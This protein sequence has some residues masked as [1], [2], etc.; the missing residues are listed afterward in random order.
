M[1]HKRIVNPLLLDI[2]FLET[3]FRFDEAR[4]QAQR[5]ISNVDN[6]ASRLRTNDVLVSDMVSTFFE[7]LRRLLWHIVILLSILTQLETQLDSNS[8]LLR[9]AIASNKQVALDLKRDEECGQKILN[10]LKMAE[11]FI[12]GQMEVSSQQI[13]AQSST[14]DEIEILKQFI[15][16]T[17]LEVRE[18]EEGTQKKI[19]NEAEKIP[20]QDKELAKL[21]EQ[22]PKLYEECQKLRQ[23]VE[24]NT[25]Q[26]I[27]QRNETDAK[28]TKM[29]AKQEEMEHIRREWEATS[30]WQKI[31]ACIKWVL[32]GGSW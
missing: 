19:A 30:T 12:Q 21:R 24:L 20:Q 31:W 16:R 22:V 7:F 6:N 9:V 4:A 25:K 10:E 14:S 28:V 23:T 11:N 13:E 17:R 15:G 26:A 3:R 32:S 5:S 8:T 29:E 1:G 18:V 2:A 27:A